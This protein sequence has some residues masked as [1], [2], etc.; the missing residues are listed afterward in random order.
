MFPASFTHPIEI[1][2]VSQWP[3]ADFPGQVWKHSPQAAWA[4]CRAA[5]HKPHPPWLYQ[6][7]S[8]QNQSAGFA[9]APPIPRPTSFAPP[10][11]KQR[12][13]STRQVS[14]DEG[15]ILIK[16]MT[17][18]GNAL[19]GLVLRP[20]RYKPA[21]TSLPHIVKLTRN[22]WFER[23]L[24]GFCCTPR[25]PFEVHYKWR[26][27]SHYRRFRIRFTRNVVISTIHQTCARFSVKE[28]GQ[29]TTPV[30]KA[31]APMFI[32]P[33]LHWL[34]KALGSEGEAPLAAR[35]HIADP[36]TIAGALLHL[37]TQVE[38]SR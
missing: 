8:L 17:W 30:L 21:R 33:C 32:R 15:D 19:T 16:K 9:K 7:A 11:T 29:A 37:I 13:E 26:Y 18:P 25:Y 34:S 36:W 38:W 12:E 27:S 5:V 10:P 1:S 3:W 23:P 14:S 2:G 31:G 35:V 20:D 28:L 24:I 4:G 22:L 6:P